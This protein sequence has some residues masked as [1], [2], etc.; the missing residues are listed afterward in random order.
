RRHTRFSRDW[1]S[2]VCSSDLGG[3]KPRRIIVDNDFVAVEFVADA[4]D[5]DHRNIVVDKG[6]KMIVLLRFHRQRYDQAADTAIV[7]RFGVEIGR[8]SCR[9]RVE[10]RTWDIS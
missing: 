8:A 3:H 10:S 4:V 6:G 2:D 5:K 1:S 7:K 9:Q